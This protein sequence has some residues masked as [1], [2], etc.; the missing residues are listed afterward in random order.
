MK[1]R[2]FLAVSLLVALFLF[3]LK[4][5]AQH[6][7]KAGTDLPLQYGIAYQ[8]TPD[9]GIGGGLK[10]GILTEPHNQIILAIMKAL[11]TKQDIIDLIDNSFKHGLILDGSSSWNWKKNYFGLNLVYINLKA[12]Q[13]PLDIVNNYY[14]IDLNTYGLG[15]LFSQDQMQIQ[16]SSDL[17]QFG[18]HFGRRISLNDKLELQIE[19]GLNKNIGSTN[20][21]TSD[22]PYP[23]LVFDPIAQ[24]LHSTYKKYAIIPSLGIYFVYN[25]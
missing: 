6:Q 1:R 11:G 7:I 10:F 15:Y 23:S 13:V 9:F 8:Y 22:F 14:G 4:A 21:L 24:D 16:L 17:L 3:A 19:I 5:Q 12:G 20:N 25:I 18:I 2:S